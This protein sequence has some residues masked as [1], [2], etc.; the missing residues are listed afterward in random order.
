MNCND[1]HTNFTSII[2][3]RDN[4]LDTYNTVKIVARNTL[5]CL[6]YFHAAKKAKLSVQQ[7]TFLS[8]AV[9]VAHVQN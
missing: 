4:L 3:R 9:V 1:I 7:P 2:I 8:M 6:E 5:F